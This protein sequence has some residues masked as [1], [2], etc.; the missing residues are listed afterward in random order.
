[1]YDSTAAVDIT[2][3]DGTLSGM[4]V[5]TMLIKNAAKSETIGIADN[6]AGVV[7]EGAS[8]T[9][10]YSTFVVSQKTGGANTYVRF[11]YTTSDAPIAAQIE[12]HCRYRPEEYGGVMGTLTAV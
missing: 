3:N 11:T 1:M 10:A 5:G 4:A 2:D 6:A 12:W 7:V 8:L 9:K